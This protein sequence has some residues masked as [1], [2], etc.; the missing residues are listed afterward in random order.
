MKRPKLYSDANEWNEEY[1]NGDVV[2]VDAHPQNLISIT[3]LRKL[4][5]RVLEKT[6]RVHEAFG[7]Y[8]EGLPCAV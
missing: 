1:I 6:S 8:E 4:T 5:L 7:G 2:H 3:D